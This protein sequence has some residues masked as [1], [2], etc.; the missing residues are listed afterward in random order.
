[1]KHAKYFNQIR[2]LN[3]DNQVELEVVEILHKLI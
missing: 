3:E 2:A 1:M